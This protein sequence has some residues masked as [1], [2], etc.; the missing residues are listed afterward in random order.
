[1]SI[2]SIAGGGAAGWPYSTRQT[3]S[4]SAADGRSGSFLCTTVRKVSMPDDLKHLDRLLRR[5]QM[6]QRRTSPPG[7]CWAPTEVDIVETQA[8][9]RRSIIVQRIPIFFRIN[10]AGDS[11]SLIALNPSLCLS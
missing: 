8:A 10:P 5:A 6:W 11:K 4:G 2:S 7:Q 3:N 1:M 9:Q